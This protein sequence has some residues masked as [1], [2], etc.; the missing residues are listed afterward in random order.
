MMEE[1]KEQRDDVPLL[2]KVRVGSPPNQRGWTSYR[3][4]PPPWGILKLGHPTTVDHS[5]T[6]DH[7][8][9]PLAFALLCLLSCLAIWSKAFVS[10]ATVVLLLSV[11][12]HFKITSFPISIARV[13]TMNGT[14]SE[15]MLVSGVT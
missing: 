6:V 8:P 13:L 10:A 14:D 4:T 12:F 3:R 2:P 15:N 7:A 5:T 1:E 9:A 11:G